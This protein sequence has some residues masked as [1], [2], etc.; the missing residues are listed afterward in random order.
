MSDTITTNGKRFPRKK[1][2]VINE[3][4]A[5]IENLSDIFADL[6]YSAYCKHESEN[7]GNEP[8]LNIGGLFT[9]TDAHYGDGAY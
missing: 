4:Y 1:V 7:K 9:N 6:L 3:S 8:D 2:F 5:G